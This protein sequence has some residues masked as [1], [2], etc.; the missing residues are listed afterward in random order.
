MA[1]ARTAPTLRVLKDPTPKRLIAST[2]LIDP[3]T[4]SNQSTCV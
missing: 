4:M 3:V 1:R 2:L